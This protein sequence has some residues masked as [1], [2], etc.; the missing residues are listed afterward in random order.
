MQLNLSKISYFLS[1]IVM[2]TVNSKAIAVESLS[3]P[4]NADSGRYWQFTSDRVMGGVSDGQVTLEKDGEVYYARLTGNVSTANNGGFIQLRSGISF[5]NSEK[6]GK[7]LQGVR[8]NVRGNGETYE[9]HIITNDRAYYGDYYSA[10]FKADSD[11]KMIDLPF[12]KFERKRYNTL[13]LDAKNIRSLSIT[14]YGRDFTSDVSVST[15]E[16]YY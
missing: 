8:L 12:N 1:L 11:W 15:I 6:G 14:A 10:T 3:Y 4:F 13:K 16:F 2:I 5:A 9:I 7:N